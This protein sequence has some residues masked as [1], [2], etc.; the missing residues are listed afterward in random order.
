M[1]FPPSLVS[2]LL[3]LL[4]PNT[5]V[6][7]A[8]PLGP[9]ARFDLCKASFLNQTNTTGAVDLHG[10]PVS[11]IGD[12]QGMTYPICYKRCG[13]GWQRDPWLSISAYLATWLIPWIALVG[14]LPFQTRSWIHDCL[15]AS[16]MIGT[17]ILA[18]HSLIITLR[19]SLWIHK[20]CR[21]EE[22][23]DR[24]DERQMKNV[25]FVLSTC[26]QIPLKIQN[27]ESLAYSIVHQ[28]N[29]R[30]WGD[31]ASHLRDTARVMPE[32]LWPQ[33]LLVLVTYGFTLSA[34][35]SVVGGTAPSAYIGE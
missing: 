13:D 25:A 33:M 11:S 8:S 21:E 22:V 1:R 7:G 20:R 34:G 16:L 24:H 18:M 27:R 14:Q 15:S 32:S 3:F 30:W 17:P 12:A 29:E 31:L 26:Q 28:R 23:V 2:L 9:I 19:N 10:N 5:N 35:F 4:I 6:L